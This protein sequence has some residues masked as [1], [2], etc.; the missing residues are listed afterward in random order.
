MQLHKEAWKNSGLQWGLNPWPCDTG[1]MLYQLS[2]EA[3]DV[4][5]YYVNDIIIY[6]LFH[7]SLTMFI[8][9]QP[10]TTKFRTKQSQNHKLINILA[11][12]LVSHICLAFFLQ[13]NNI[14]EIFLV[15]MVFDCLFEILYIDF[16]FLYL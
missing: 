15:F 16:V 5:I 12:S 2:Y 6:D 10:I 13:H 9:L 14:P 8:V 3:S 7:I 4:D 11:C 1:A